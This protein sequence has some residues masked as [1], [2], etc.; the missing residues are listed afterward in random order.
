M[1]ERFAAT[2]NP[3]Q[4]PDFTCSSRGGERRGRFDA[5][6]SPEELGRGRDVAPGGV[7]ATCRLQTTNQEDVCV[8]VVGIEPHELGGVVRRLVGFAARK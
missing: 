1:V 4:D 5:E 6:V 8:L 3:A 2:R 7:R